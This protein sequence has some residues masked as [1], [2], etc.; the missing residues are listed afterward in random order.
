MSQFINFGSNPRMSLNENK[1][2]TQLSELSQQTNDVSKQL[3]RYQQSHEQQS[4]ERKK[5]EKF[6]FYKMQQKRLQEMSFTKDN[7]NSSADHLIN[8][9]IERVGSEA[10]LDKRLTNASNKQIINPLVSSISASVMTPMNQNMTTYCPQYSNPSFNSVP[11]NMSLFCS[12]QPLMTSV[13]QKQQQYVNQ[14]QNNSLL[15]PQTLSLNTTPIVSQMSINPISSEPNYSSAQTFNVEKRT[16]NHYSGAY[17]PN[18]SLSQTSNQTTNAFNCLN[19]GNYLINF[20][21]RY[22]INNI[23]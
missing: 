3:G 1:V 9:I 5:F 15:Y 7:T 14:Y 4:D 17:I 18:T 8:N 22:L 13:N 6:R 19:F 10:K 2:M 11:Q 23:L 16:E 12:T 20:Y 21:F